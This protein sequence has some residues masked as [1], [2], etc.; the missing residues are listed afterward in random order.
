MGLIIYG[1]VSVGIVAFTALI[2][3]LRL[4]QLRE[5]TIVRTLALLVGQNLPLVAGLHEAA[6]QERRKLRRIFNELS[7]RLSGG[8]SLSVALRSAF[9]SC[10]GVTLGAIRAAEQAGTLPTVLR[11]LAREPDR[12]G[13][14]TG[15]STTPI[16]YAVIVPMLTL[17]IFLAVGTFLVPKFRDICRDFGLQSMPRMTENLIGI[18]DGL[19]A[20]LGLVTIAGCVILLLG[21]Q[22]L[23]GRFIWVRRPDALQ[24]PYVMLD[25]LIWS[26]P[27]LRRIAQTRALARQTPILLAS[28]R[29]GHDLPAAARQAALVDGNVFARRRLWRWAENIEQGREPLDAAR[30]AGLPQSLCAVLSKARTPAELAAA[31]EYAGSYYRR[32]LV[33]WE[34]LFVSAAG[35]TMVLLFGL[36]IGY[37]VVAFYLPLKALIDQVMAGIY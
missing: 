4:R 14:S 29:V 10:S 34:R 32:L 13:R 6:Q 36:G 20:H 35:P 37:A 24:W 31:L 2:A 16:V 33:H 3:R 30:A 26:L 12:P 25:A 17:V 1:I 5:R 19:T 11:S 8:S 9:S 15:R 23:I 18:A 22:M 28:I 21:M 7:R 27:P